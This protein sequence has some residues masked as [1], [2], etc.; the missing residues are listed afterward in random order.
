MMIIVRSRTGRIGTG[1]SI[2]AA[3]VGLVAW[4]ISPTPSKAAQTT[5]LPAP[6]EAATTQPARWR[7]AWGKK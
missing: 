7:D 5:A 2:V 6:A 1:L 4:A 3:A